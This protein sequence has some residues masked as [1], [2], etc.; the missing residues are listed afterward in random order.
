M[1]AKR[2][3]LQKSL[4]SIR[5]DFSTA[6]CSTEFFFYCRTNSNQQTSFDDLELQ[7][8]IHHSI[9]HSFQSH[10]FYGTKQTNGEVLPR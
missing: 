4:D 3:T 1:E 7:A 5:E 9:E 2:G 6:I 10:M 8:P